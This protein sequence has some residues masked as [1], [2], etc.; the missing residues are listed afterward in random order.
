MAS[1]P[2]R[3]V[4]ECGDAH[5]DTEPALVARLFDIG[6]APAPQTNERTEEDT[7]SVYRLPI[8][9]RDILESEYCR[10]INS[11]QKGHWSSSDYGYEATQFTDVKDT[12][13][14]PGTAETPQENCTQGCP[15]V[16]MWSRS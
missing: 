1:H 14:N 13:A 16:R 5:G 8:P 2:L 4:Y 15:S 6:V 10:K 3:R 9:G 12:C 11:S 7:E